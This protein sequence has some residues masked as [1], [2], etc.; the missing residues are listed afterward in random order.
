MIP[1][2]N[3]C[4]VKLTRRD[5]P[6]HLQHD[7]PKR[8][9]KCEFC[10]SEFTGEAFEV[11]PKNNEQKVI[12]IALATLE[13]VQWVALAFSMKTGN[14]ASSSLGPFPQDAFTSTGACLVRANQNCSVLGQFD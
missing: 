13:N 6:E 5:L 1:C 14:L 4:S 8:K 7:C 10:G 12:V 11:H 2:P 9:V 3:R